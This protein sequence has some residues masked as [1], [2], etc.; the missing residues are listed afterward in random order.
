MARTQ[1][2]EG[3]PEMT[4]NSEHDDLFD[5]LR[6]ANPFVAKGLTPDTTTSPEA[7]FKEIT[8]QPQDTPVPRRNPAAAPAQWWRRPMIAAPTALALAAII[9]IGA[10]VASTINAPSAY[11]LVTEAAQKSASFESGRVRVEIELRAVPDDVSGTFVLDSRFDGDNYSLAQDMSQFD[12]SGADP[13]ELGQFTMMRVDGTL[14]SSIPGIT[15]DGQFLAQPS[16][17][18][19][20]LGSDLFGSVNPETLTPQS[21]VTILQRAD[22]FS[23]I[24]STGDATSYRGSVPLNVLQEIGPG[25]LPPGLALLAEGG[26]TDDLPETITVTAIVVDGTIDRLVIDIIGDTP[27]GYTD[28][29]ITTTFSELGEP[30]NI[31]APPVDQQ[32]TMADLDD[33]VMEPPAE[34]KEALDLL[35]ELEQRRPGLCQEA[36][37]EFDEQAASETFEMDELDFE[38]MA[39]NFAIC[40]EDAGELEAAEAFRAMNQFG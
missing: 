5:E 36:F 16:A 32:I 6:A 23:E 37:A 21:I 10:L 15:A 17:A 40:L 38:L 31:V 20:P 25:D 4:H 27:T 8:M 22:D 9:A 18:V 34:I 39:E 12:A 13:A 24:D 1:R 33:G 7:R 35:E 30:Q 19:D 14:Y 3:R 28:A 29:T 2:P 26:P 11:A